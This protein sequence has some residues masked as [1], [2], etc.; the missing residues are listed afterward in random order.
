MVLAETKETIEDIA[1][2]AQAEIAS[3][4]RTCRVTAQDDSHITHR[5]PRAKT[6]RARPGISR[7]FTVCC[8]LRHF[9]DF[10][11]NETC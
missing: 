10:V 7:R 4:Q 6:E 3:G 2:E 5:L 1:A 8:H 11:Q 9:P